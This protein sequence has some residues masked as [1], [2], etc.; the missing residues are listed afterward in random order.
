M[1]KKLT[2]IRLI[3]WHYFGNETIEVEGSFLITGDN[4]SGKSTILDAI[5][6]V[7]TTNTRKF[8]TAANEKS[9]RDLKG[10]VRCKTGDEENIYNRKGSVICYV[11]LEFFEESKSNYFTIGAK[12]DS[13]D[14]E[15]KLDVRWFVTEC[16]LEEL[17][18][19][20]DGRPSMTDEF[21]RGSDSNIQ[22]ITQVGEA[23]ARF[24]RRLGNLEDRFF[25]MI[26]KS[27]AFKP[28]DKVKDFI[29]RFILA[30]KRIEVASLRKNISLLKEFEDLMAVTR[31]KIASLEQILHKHAEIEEKNR[32]I[33]INEILIRKAQIE[34][35][36]ENLEILQKEIYLLG[37]RLQ[38]VQ[39]AIKEAENRYASENER[40]L[41]LRI[42]FEQNSTTKLISDTEN[43]LRFLRDE[44]SRI[45]TRLDKFR[46]MLR[47]LTALLDLLADRGRM[48]VGKSQVQKFADPA[49]DPDKLSVLIYDLQQTVRKIQDEYRKQEFEAQARLTIIEETKIRLEKEIRDLRDK[50]LI[51]PENTSRLKSV[52]EEEFTRRGIDS[53]VRVFSDLL[54]IND[55]KWQDAIEGYLNT[56]RFYLIVEPRHYP[57]ALDVYHRHKQEI[58][59]VGLVNTGRLDLEAA[60]TPESLAYLVS[61]D[62]R[63]AQAYANYLLDRVVRCDNIGQLKEHKVAITADCMLYQ[64]C[65]VRKLDARIYN[66]PYIGARAYVIQLARREEELRDLSTEQEDL[67]RQLTGMRQVLAA[68][69]AVNFD[70]ISENL[71]APAELIRVRDNIEEKETQLAKARSNPNFIEIQLEL[72]KCQSRVRSYDQQKNQQ[73]A[74]RAKIEQEVEQKKLKLAE[75]GK[76]LEILSSAFQE[77]CDLD[78]ETAREGLGKFSEQIRQKSAGVIRQN[79]APYT[80]GLTN[81]RELFIDE[82]KDLQRDYD[83]DYDCDFGTGTDLIGAYRDEHHKLISSEIIKYEDQLEQ[84]KKNCELEF[85]ESFLARLQEYIHQAEIEFKNLNRALS[86]IYYG[87]DSYKFDITGNK[88]K[89]SLY[90]M[91]TSE[92]NVGGFNLWSSSFE[93]E[94]REEMNDLFDKL[95]AYDDTGDKVIEEY[96]DYR[97]YLDYDIIVRKRDGGEL[98]FSRIYGEKS[99]GETQ[100][101]YYVAIAASFVQLYKAGNTIRII[102]LDEAFDKMDDNRIASMLD[103]FNSQDFQIILAT[104]PSKMEIIGEKVDTILVT[105]REGSNTIV[106]EYDL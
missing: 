44:Q 69:D 71:S 101:P 85:K 16:R 48:Q 87:E 3:N 29:N 46:H 94:Y 43:E 11:A 89:E 14:E 21:R 2:K 95:T 15:S 38:K 88:K 70:L 73:I 61:S 4:T 80:Q 104:T 103:F 83:K 64:G 67:R 75:D 26:P 66:P 84:A 23:K 100:T 63:Y 86:G 57:A 36:R 52:I 6:L 72:E 56:Q 79:F 54:E 91:I 78:A 30:E 27:L 45:E 22:L 68:A 49:Q 31:K 47:K 62:N 10:Y 105:I 33:R 92:R 82:L 24:A 74:A 9:R 102:M 53:P 93:D 65:A 17:A 1:I 8:N 18:F 50:K 77:F 7:L 58:H 106:E 5:Q 13:P 37:S 32:D 81:R 41:N 28:M 42:S 40:L 59:S 76:Q 60:A 39:E 20:T 25:D 34:E 96:T 97:S 51:Y 55:E 35:S 19:I 12:I 99:G 98:R 90:R